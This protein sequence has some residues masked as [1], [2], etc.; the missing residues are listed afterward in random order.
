MNSPGGSLDE[1]VEGATKTRL[2]V[3]ESVEGVLAVVTTHP[4]V[5]YA[6]ERHIITWKKQTLTT[7]DTPITFLY[8]QISKIYF[9]H[10]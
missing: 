2:V 6:A 3:A 10:E 8:N 5:P 1:G 7:N 4:A 9:P